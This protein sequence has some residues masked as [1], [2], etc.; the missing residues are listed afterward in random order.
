MSPGSTAA[1][2]MRSL[3]QGLQTSS[4][5]D[6]VAEKYSCQPP[7]FT[8]RDMLPK[9]TSKFSNKTIIMGVVEIWI[10]SLVALS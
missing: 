4:D 6:Q 2:D 3:M 1:E 5:M 8:Y 9:P 7:E 10:V